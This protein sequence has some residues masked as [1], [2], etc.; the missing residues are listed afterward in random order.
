MGMYRVKI[1][2]IGEAILEVAANSEDDS[3]EVALDEVVKWR[4]E[5]FVKYLDL[6]I[7]NIAVKSMSDEPSEND[8]CMEDEDTDNQ[9]EGEE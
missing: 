9:E 3:V 7:N 2:Y 1:E 4:E 5:E 6:H 8:N